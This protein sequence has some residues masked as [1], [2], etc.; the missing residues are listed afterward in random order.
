[1]HEGAD[2]FQRVACG[3]ITKA[4]LKTTAVLQLCP[5]KDVFKSKPL[6]P[7]NIILFENRVFADWSR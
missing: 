4:L 5:P 2:C 6:M 1:M 7:V 3:F